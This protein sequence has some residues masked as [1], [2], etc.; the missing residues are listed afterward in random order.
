MCA[1][2]KRIQ[3]CDLCVQQK[4]QVEDKKKGKGLDKEGSSWRSMRS[5]AKTS[6][7]SMK[8]RTER[9]YRELFVCFS[10]RS[11]V[12]PLLH[13]C[14]TKTSDNITVLVLCWLPGR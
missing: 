6:G 7:E 1:P 9:S 8:F 13:H 4:E 12:R 14:D 10:I 5:L 3:Y 11:C 2:C